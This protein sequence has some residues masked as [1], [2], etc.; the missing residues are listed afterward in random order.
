MGAPLG[1]GLAITGRLIVGTVA[2]RRAASPDVV[3]RWVATMLAVGA[4]A[5]VC[6]GLRTPAAHWLALT[7][8]FGAGWA[9]SGAF[10][11]AVVRARTRSPGRATGVSQTGI[12]VDTTAGP[13]V[14]GP[15][16]E[17]VGYGPTW[18]VAA[19][20]ALVG[21]WA[22]PWFGWVRAGVLR[23]LTG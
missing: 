9:W 10:N 2:D 22:W 8:A 20:M 1:S 23:R 16:S 11:L 12:Y 19:A 17:H 5:L 15:L 7:P 6:F 13:L 4:L 21:A 3:L 18:A 14:L